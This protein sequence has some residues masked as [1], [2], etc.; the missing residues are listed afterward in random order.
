MP[1]IVDFL[2]LDG[3]I[4]VAAEANIAKRKY[5]VV[6]QLTCEP[7]CCPRCGETLVFNGH[8]TRSFIDLPRGQMRVKVHVA[9]PRRL[10]RICQ[11]TT[12]DELAGLATK[13]NVSQ[14]ALEYVYA[15]L[16]ARKPRVWIAREIG[17]GSRTLDRICDEWRQA[18]EQ[19]RVAECAEYMG[20]DEIYVHGRAYCPITDVGNG[21]VIDLLPQNN[22]ET[23]TPYL[24][25]LAHPERV[26]AVAM[27]LC[28]HYR[29]IIHE[30]WPHAAVVADKA[31]VL[32]LARQQFDRIRVL[33]AR[34]F[35]RVGRDVSRKITPE[36]KSEQTNETL[37]RETRKKRDNVRKKLKADRRL[38]TAPKS[39]LSEDQ[40]AALEAW[41]MT[42]PALRESYILLQSIY[43]WYQTDMSSMQ[44]AEDL[45]KIRTEMSPE[46][47]CEWRSFFGTVD[48]FFPEI[49]AYFDIGLTNAYT[50]AVNRQIRDIIAAGRGLR[51]S[52]LRARVIFTHAPSHDLPGYRHRAVPLP[53]PPRALRR[54]HGHR[55]TR[56]VPR[57][58][59]GELF[60]GDGGGE[61]DSVG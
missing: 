59:Q 17:I 38:F 57:A 46:C 29:Q 50:E 15:Q 21:R 32:T 8:Y 53:S 54:P 24:R 47:Q 35:V 20:I 60:A 40:K 30:V 42:F 12:S 19:S 41:W 6:A 48:N 39:K 22:A 56:P 45:A 49:L 61:T 28:A 14:R 1:I 5:D 3:Y 26:R 18:R 33:T 7:R 2:D 43:I 9:V 4:T 44:A 11:V 37:A 36:A 16:E 10:C 52:E 51:F 31:H 27:D 34:E 58:S 25:S 55:H 23:I 13:H